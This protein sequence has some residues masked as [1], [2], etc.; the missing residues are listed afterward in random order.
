MTTKQELDERLDK[1]Q[2]PSYVHIRMVDVPAFTGKL[3]ECIQ[4]Y[5]DYV[6]WPMVVLGAYRDVAIILEVKRL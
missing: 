3:Q 4:V 5:Q 1:G 2:H 6:T